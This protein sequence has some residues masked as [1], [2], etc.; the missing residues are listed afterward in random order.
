MFAIN[1]LPGKYIAPIIIQRPL[2]NCSINDL[3]VNIIINNVKHD[4]FNRIHPRARSIKIT[5]INRNQIFRS[6]GSK[7]FF[8]TWRDG[9][10]RKAEGNSRAIMRKT[11][12]RSRR[13]LKRWAGHIAPLAASAAVRS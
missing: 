2:F 6:K 12:Q 5:Q 9:G 13:S 1:T 4:N 10:A 7:H 11:N 8:E 3:T